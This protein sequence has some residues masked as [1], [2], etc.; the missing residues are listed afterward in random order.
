MKRIFTVI[1]VI[2]AFAALMLAAGMLAAADKPAEPAAPAPAATQAGG[3][4]SSQ[5]VVVTGQL[6]IKIESAKP[7]IPI[8]TDA[9][10]VAESVVKTEEDFMSLAPEDIKDVRMGLPDKIAEDRPEYH[11]DLYFLETQPIFKLSAKLPA[12]VEIDT[13]SFKVTDPT[14]AV[15]ARE[16][17]SGNLPDQFVWDGFDQNGQMMKLNAPYIYELTLMDKAGNP[18]RVRRKEPKSVEA[19]KYYDK[20][21]LFI[22]VSGSV[23]FDKDRT[24]RFTDQGKQIIT[25]VEDY[26]K[27]SNRFPIEILVYADDAG[28]AKDQADS[29][30]LIFDRTMKL[31]K[32]S[33]V[34]RTVQDTSIPRNFRIVFILN[35]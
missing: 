34:M 13:W 31:P 2:S 5:E 7:E 4:D 33:F 21:K 28:L 6:K 8:K 20:G 29:L 1:T 35:S 17:G 16:K 15:V 27:M 18:S 3:G 14:G 23:L 19:I 22:E 32:N 11:A 30:Q 26:I 12:G 25:E 10:Q 24:D 9:N